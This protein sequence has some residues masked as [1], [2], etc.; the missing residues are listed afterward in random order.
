MESKWF[1]PPFRGVNSSSQNNHHS[2]AEPCEYKVPEDVFGELE[3]RIKVPENEYQIHNSHTMNDKFF[4]F[5]QSIEKLED[6]LSEIEEEHNIKMFI[7]REEKE[8]L[9]SEVN[10]I[11]TLKAK[12]TD[13]SLQ[14]LKIFSQ[15]DEIQCAK[16]EISLL[17]EKVEQIIVSE[18]NLSFRFQERRD[19]LK[20]IHEECLKKEREIQIYCQEYKKSIKDASELNGNLALINKLQKEKNELIKVFIEKANKVRSKP[21]DF[22]TNISKNSLLISFRI[23]K[24]QLKDIDHEISNTPNDIVYPHDFSRL[25]TFDLSDS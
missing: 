18:E 1:I 7:C 10:E 23:L 20:H 2:K 17:K 11:N 6:S 3:T 24:L 12:R 5:K 22:Q 14:Q 21:E 16:E 13:C 15:K 19:T 8:K 9:I 25:Q 4:M